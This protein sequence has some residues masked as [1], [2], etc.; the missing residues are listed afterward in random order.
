MRYAILTDLSG[1]KSVAR[2]LGYP[3]RKTISFISSAFNVVRVFSASCQ[4]KIVQSIVPCIPVDVIYDAGF[5]QRPSKNYPDECM[6]REWVSATREGGEH[7]GYHLPSLFSFLKNST[8]SNLAGIHR[9]EPAPC[10][11]RLEVSP[12]SLSPSQITRA[13]IVRKT[14]VQERLAGVLS[15]SLWRSLFDSRV[16]PFYKP[17][18]FLR[19]LPL[20]DDSQI[21]P[22]VVSG[23]PV[24]VV[25]HVSVRDIDAHHGKDDSGNEKRSSLPVVIQTNRSPSVLVLTSSPLASVQ[26]IPAVHAGLNAPLSSRP[27]VMQGTSLPSKF[28][29][30]REVLKCLVKKLSPW[31]G[32][33]F[34]VGMAKCADIRQ[35]VFHNFFNLMVGARAVCSSNLASPI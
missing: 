33:D 1:V 30:F 20:S 13:W 29:A 12:R 25:N 7:D 6:C 3:L 17:F 31:S 22:S 24:N 34:Y 21:L 2:S 23:I 10:L 8:A 4:S 11:I 16:N 35:I 5:W 28:P 9:V 15:S 14:F 26:S 27:E 18:G 32:V 19:V